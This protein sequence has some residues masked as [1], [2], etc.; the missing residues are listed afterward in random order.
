MKASSGIAL[1]AA[2]ALLPGCRARHEAASTGQ[3]DGQ[4][5]YHGHRQ[6]QIA[7]TDS[8]LRHCV[9]EIE[10]PAV[11]FADSIGRR[12]VTLKAK[13]IVIRKDDRRHVI[14]VSLS[15][16]DSAAAR[17]AS[18]RSATMKKSR[19]GISFPAWLKA[20]LIMLALLFAAKAAWQMLKK[21]QK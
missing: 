16:S 1:A 14:A 7:L 12:D 3:H 20:G 4:E 21:T 6:T 8:I 2:L 18:C 10:A 15:K 11:K 13:T 5:L 9:I 17:A 19:L